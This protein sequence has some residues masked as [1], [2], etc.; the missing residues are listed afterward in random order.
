MYCRT[1]GK[2]I[3][4]NSAFCTYCG[5]TTLPQPPFPN[6]QPENFQ[7][8]QPDKINIGIIFVCIFVP[9]AGI[10]LGVLNLKD[11]KKKLGKV[12]LIVSIISTVFAF[13]LE[14]LFMVFILWGFELFIRAFNHY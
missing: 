2:E 13:I 6:G 14:V 8:K 5:C 10:I 7:E 12:Y 3:P 4:E 11:G 9:I 1:C